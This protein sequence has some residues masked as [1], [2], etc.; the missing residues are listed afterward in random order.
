MLDQADF[1][2]RYD[3]SDVLSLMM[4]LPEQLSHKFAEPEGV[5]KLGKV[6]NIVLAGM[7]GS[8][9]PGEFLK[10]W[11]GD[12]LPVPFVIVRDYT[13]P[14]FVN[15]NTL[16]IASSYSGNTEET[17]SGLLEAKARGA[18]TAVIATGGKL[19]GIAKEQ[20]IVH[21]EL[22]VALQPRMAVFYSVNAFATLFEG[23]GLLKGITKDLSD[24]GK[25]LHEAHMQNWSA[26]SETKDN[27]A[28]EIA[29]ELVGHPVVVY[30][31]QALAFAAMKWKIGI[32]ENAKNI[33]FYNY[34]PEL[35]HNEFIGW[36]HPQNS[37]LKVVE[38]RS[39]LDH[40]RVQKRFDVTNRLRSDIFSPI[41]V[42]A[43]GET[44][45]EQLIW[46][47]ALGEFVATYLAI[48]NQVDPFPV[49]LVEKF[50]ME[51]G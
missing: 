15:H 1:I 9:Q 50:K 16:V 48:L 51:L 6:D 7:G 10:T 38:L 36:G 3:K 24:A 14:G 5:E 42:T 25:W 49:D 40:P 45:L 29:N 20:G 35:N 28:K 39:D 30:A 13:L 4:G 33:A 32:N 47:I 19:L 17:I 34:F 2:A 11:L 27:T 44:K 41:Q 21:I 18:R 46:T 8:A 12:K 31:G 23:M 26:K 37:G 22:P 43:E